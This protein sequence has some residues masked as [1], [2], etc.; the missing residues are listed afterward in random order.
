MKPS[1][2]RFV[3]T[4]EIKL[5]RQALVAAIRHGHVIA[6][7]RFLADEAVKAYRERCLTAG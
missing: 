6:E 7:A 5:W 2:I 3:D 4:Y 1:T